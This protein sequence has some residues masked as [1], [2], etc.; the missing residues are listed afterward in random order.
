MF[1]IM[2]IEVDVTPQERQEAA[3]W[4]YRKKN[5]WR[6]FTGGAVAIVLAASLLGMVMRY[7][8]KTPT[9][10]LAGRTAA[11]PVLWLAAVAIAAL[12]YGKHSPKQAQAAFLFGPAVYRTAFTCQITDEGIACFDGETRIASFS[13]LALHEVKNTG[14]LLLVETDGPVALILPL[15]CFASEED[16][17][18]AEL[19]LNNRLHAKASAAVP[20]LKLEAAADSLWKLQFWTDLSL[21]T[22]AASLQ[23]K[24]V[25]SRKGWKILFF[26]LFSLFLVVVFLSI[27]FVPPLSV[28]PFYLF[29]LFALFLGIVLSR[30]KAGA[31]GNNLS[32]ICSGTYGSCTLEAL[33]SGL[34]F[35]NTKMELFFGWENPFQVLQ[36]PAVAVVTLYGSAFAFLPSSAAAPPVL[37]TA[38][39]YIE[40][41]PQ[42]GD[43]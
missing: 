11:Y 22:L 18:Q 39:E 2:Q 38:L 8:G 5:L 3:N 10:L 12:F 41:P 14:K 9:L 21:A 20:Q 42:D 31:A 1:V 32:W 17:R 35:Y 37:N 25:F 36:D 6:Y 16:A 40:S 24:A 33:P 43:I 19:L 29:G 13:Y 26:V 23:K 7:A 30:Q 28:L 34:R 4:V 27:V 15:R